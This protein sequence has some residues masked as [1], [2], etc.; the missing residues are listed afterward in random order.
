MFSLSLLQG[1]RTWKPALAPKLSNA[2]ELLICEGCGDNP[3]WWVCGAD[4][5]IPIHITNAPLIRRNALC[6]D[7]NNNSIKMNEKKMW[8]GRKGN[9]RLEIG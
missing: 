8:A 4:R 9:I 6:N 5:E 1:W 3:L 7:K 2:T